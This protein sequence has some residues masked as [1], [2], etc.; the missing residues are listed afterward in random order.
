MATALSV[1]PQPRLVASPLHTAGLIL[2]MVALCLMGMYQQSR[3]SADP[4]LVPA[5]RGIIPLYVSL[6]ISEW[7][8]VLYVRAGT[9]KRKVPLREL[10][11]GRW[12]GMKDILRDL[13]IAAVFW[14][15]WAGVAWLVHL[16]AGPNHAK[17]VA[18]LLPRGLMEIILWVV[19]SM[20]AGFCEELVFRGYLQRQFLGLLGSGAAAVLVQAVVFG[21]GHAYQ[22][23]KQVVVIVVLGLL[24]GWLA[25]WCRSIR[26]GVFAHTWSD[27]FSGILARS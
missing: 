4:T 22:G 5:H 3:P 13:A 18:I 27:I 7:A 1:S 16:F 20:S 12:R 26:P 11:G 25:L 9:R 15:I 10:I 2:I 6:I 23:T 21:I 17:T 19:V 14:P 8:L 24:Y